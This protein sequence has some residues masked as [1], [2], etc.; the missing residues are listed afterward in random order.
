MATGTTTASNKYAPNAERAKFRERVDELMRKRKDPEYVR[1]ALEQVGYDTSVIDQELGRYQS[2]QTGQPMQQVAQA[3]DYG[4]L[5]LSPTQAQAI[6]DTNATIDLAAQAKE[7]AK[8]IKTGPL[9]GR[10]SRGKALLQSGGDENFNKLDAQL[11][12][13]KANFMKALSGAAVSEQEATRL[14]KFLP[15]ATDQESVIQTKLDQLAK[16]LKIKKDEMISVAGG[17]PAEFEKQTA[18]GQ[19]TQTAQPVKL[20]TP[21]EAAKWLES[22]P[23]DPRAEKV[24]Q[25]LESVGYKFPLADSAAPESG[26]EAPKEQGFLSTLG[27]EIP[28]LAGKVL[29]RFSNAY[30]DVQGDMTKGN[31]PTLTGRAGLRAAG[32]IGGSINDAFTSLIEVGYS[33]LPKE[34]KEVLKDTALTVAKSDVGQAGL[35]AFAKGAEEWQQYKAEN[36]ERAKDI[37]DVANVLAAIPAGKILGKVK[38][39]TKAVTKD[40]L[41]VLGR[42]NETKATT[43]VFKAIKPSI[44]VGRN[45]STAKETVGKANK[46]IIDLGIKAPTNVREYT[47]ALTEAK[48]RVWQ[49]IETKLSG[50]GTTKVDIGTIADRVKQMADDPNLL[51]IDQRAASKLANI[52][53]SLESQG[54]EMSV[55]DAESLKQYINSELKGAFGKFNLSNAEQNAKKM[56]TAE[57]GKQLDDILSSVPNEFSDMKKLY[58]AVRQTEEDALKRLVVF[59]RQ[60][61]Q[62]LI[63]SYSKIS[64][65][66]NIIKGVATLNPSEVVKGASEV[67]MGQV[68]RRANDADTLIKKAF[69]RLDTKKGGFDSWLFKTVND[70][71]GKG[72]LSLQDVSGGKAGYSGDLLQEARKYK[73][74]EEFVKAQEKNN[75]LYEAAKDFETANDFKSFFRGSATQYGKY[76][77]EIRKFGTTE[78]SVRVPEL[79][80]NPE[81]KITIYRGLD[82]SIGKIKGRINDGDFVTTDYDSAA[83]Y[84]DGKV[85]SKEVKAKDL[86][87][88]YPEK[89]DYENPFYKGAEFIYS[90]SKNKLVKYSDTDLETIFNDAKSYKLNIPISELERQKKYIQKYGEIPDGADIKGFSK[91]PEYGKYGT[92]SKS[93]KSAYYEYVSN[94][95]DEAIKTKSQLTDIW[96]K[97]HGETKRGFGTGAG[98][99]KNEMEKISLNVGEVYTK[100]KKIKESILNELADFT[101]YAAKQ[102][103]GIKI[104]RVPEEIRARAIAEKLG[105]NPD[106]SNWMLSKK[107]GKLL[108]ENNWDR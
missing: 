71:K 41:Q 99:M 12:S 54:R 2:V 95:I 69:E 73:S 56:I 26:V 13:I 92:D 25:K 16:E 106:I 50:A 33:A 7:M 60:N 77:P 44:T 63:E 84:A 79:G 108:K 29:D 42:S 18:A 20:N 76:R 24:R 32:A 14:S 23:N 102:K 91:S 87:L 39:E 93:Q 34:T 61:P 28:E 55:A 65:V 72:G 38:G 4:S 101:D 83:A 105:M 68:Q 90:N 48:Q 22:N 21:E 85:V 59:E 27:K 53:R 103:Q 17:N 78:E 19:T 9:E 89:S 37:E 82:E 94:K 5:G 51:R 43:E 31:L 47:T 62:G 11:N 1:F 70:I 36:P 57:I 6:A 46:A 98:R 3:P 45:L 104:E 10:I 64:G 86:I 58:G 30:S 15:D 35:S 67:I 52:A 80:I 49:Q 81:K 107:F 8:G 75:P 88:D 66:G 97:A 74:A 100:G 96:K 40:T